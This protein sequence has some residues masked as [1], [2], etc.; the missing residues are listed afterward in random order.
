MRV[1]L[2]RR[3]ANY[4]DGVNLSARGVGDVFELARADAELL[5]AEGWAVH[6]APPERPRLFRTAVVVSRAAPE[7]SRHVP[8]AGQLRDIGEQ[9]QRR[10]FPP[11]DQR[12]AEDLIREAWHDQHARVIKS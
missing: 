10:L 8:L 2:I 9:M 5:I 1:R 6:A 11:R 7:G 4:I 3:L 12:R